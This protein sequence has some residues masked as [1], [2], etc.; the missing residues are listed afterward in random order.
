[1]HTRRMLLAALLVVAL[2]AAALVW[3]RGAPGWIP[4]LA[5]GLGEHPRA[6]GITTASGLYQ[7]SM[8][9]QIVTHEPGVCPICQ[10]GLQ[11]VDDAGASGS[12][13]AAK[14]REVLFYRHPMRADVTSPV[15]ARDE[16]GMDYIPVYAEEVSGDDDAVPGR[17]SFTLPTERQQLIGVTKA[18]VERRPLTLEI[19][20]VGKVAYDPGL[21]QTIVEYREAI[22]AKAQLKE[23][24]WPEA[25]Q[26]A[27]AIIRA[28]RLK[29]RQQ[30]LSEAQIQE[31]GAGGRDPV[32]LLLPGKSVWVYA[33]VYE[34]EMDLIQ[35]GQPLVVSAPSLPGRSYNARVTAVDPIL[36]A[37]TRTARVRVRVATPDES[38][39]PETFVHV[40][41]EVSLGELLAV[42]EEAVLHT[43]AHAIIFVVKG[44]GEFEP[45]SVRL[46]RNG[47]GYYEVLSGLAEGEQVVTSANF[48][49]DSES[50]FRAALAAFGKKSSAGHSH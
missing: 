41:I 35:P 47:A 20:T 17:A 3:W 32:E 40:R 49:I 31:L 9:P 8:H 26:G 2:G 21:Y 48:L 19:R 16:M 24:P 42:P 43:G 7:C 11:P 36:N 28:V 46:G 30:G 6:N 1:M 13:G 27:D 15:P 50:R 18:P 34:Y 39:R 10:M 38:L 29:L 14:K 22:A 4:G 37:A 45:R 44:E 33:Q 12:P 5:D 23:S 25:R